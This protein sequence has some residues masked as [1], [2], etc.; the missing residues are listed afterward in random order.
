MELYAKTLVERFS[1][2]LTSNIY[3]NP[4]S[5]S[6]P[7][8]L[9][10]T[11][12]DRIRERALRFFN[13]SPKD[14]DLIFVANA[15]AAVKLVADAFQDASSDPRSPDGSPGFWYGWH[16]D[17]HS[18]IVGLREVTNGFHHCFHSDDDVQRWIN[19]GCSGHEGFLGL[20]AFPGQSNMTG[21]RLPLTW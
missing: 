11:C 20:F 8:A 3:G 2:D 5:G 6:N 7:A 4:H 13:A 1:K 12:V 14:F 17:A 15:T 16:R 19:D 18:S 10:A 9:S 21:R